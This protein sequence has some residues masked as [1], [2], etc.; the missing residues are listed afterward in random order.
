MANPVS[1]MHR[2]RSVVAGVKMHEFIPGL[3]PRLAPGLG[4]FPKEY[5]IDPVLGRDH[6][7]GLGQ[8]SSAPPSPSYSLA[9][10][11]MSEL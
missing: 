8:R 10:L 11:G 2:S 6:P 1:G 4:R 5:R 3:R 7:I 9:P